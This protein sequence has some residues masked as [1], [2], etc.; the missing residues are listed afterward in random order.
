MAAPGLEGLAT[1]GG[2]RAAAA[3]AALP[4]IAADAGFGSRSAG[5]GCRSAGFAVARREGAALAGRFGG[6]CLLS[7]S[8]SPALDPAKRKTNKQV[9]TPY[10]DASRM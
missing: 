10:G 2:R 5:L 9:S 1:A 7:S 6:V 4:A 8:L 3:R